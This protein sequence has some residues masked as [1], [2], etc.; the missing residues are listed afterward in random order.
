MKM[1]KMTMSSLL[2]AAAIIAAGGFLNG[3]VLRM[4]EPIAGYTC[5]NLHPE[6]GWVSSNNVQG[7]PIIPAGQ[8][9]NFSSIKRSYYVYGTVGGQSISLR[10]DAAQNKED[11][12][13]W[14]R[15]IVVKDD[16]RLQLASWSP[17]VQ[18]AVR[19]AKVMVGMTR[20]QVLMSLGHPSP[21]DTADLS[22]DA[23]RYWTVQDDAPVDVIF[24]SDGCVSAL[25]GSPMAVRTIEFER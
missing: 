7:G 19:N 6:Y 21:N 25:S 22:G 10:D 13:R 3:C 12:L 5:C 4:D 9:A 23:W 17:Q 24:G 8:P 15:R 20:D 18:S 11:T 2:K 16:P 1:M 14:V